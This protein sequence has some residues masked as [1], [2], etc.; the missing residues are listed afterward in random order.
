[1]LFAIGSRVRLN[2]TG[3]EG[4]VSE[5]L[6]HGM[7]S[8]LLDDGDEI[9]VAE[10]DLMRIEDYRATLQKQTSCQ[11]KSHKKVLLKKSLKSQIF[12]NFN[13]NIRF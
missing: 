10:E 7:I 2:H 11:S 4:T 6:D 8:V 5:L 9:P 13:L 3:A 12:R 1:M